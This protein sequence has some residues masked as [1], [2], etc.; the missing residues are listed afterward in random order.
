MH[1][2]CPLSGFFVS[3]EHRIRHS[4]QRSSLGRCFSVDWG[5]AL[6]FSQGD[7]SNICIPQPWGES[8]HPPRLGRKS[9]PNCSVIEFKSDGPKI[10]NAFPSLSQP[11]RTPALLHPP[12]QAPLSFG[13]IS[14]QSFF[15]GRCFI[16]VV[17]LVP[18]PSYDHNH[19]I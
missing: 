11:K 7:A 5:R 16:I 18:F 17:V 15:S 14:F 12:R 1:S 6:L 3:F 19:S 2:S 10:I 4:L 9:H 8:P 13:L